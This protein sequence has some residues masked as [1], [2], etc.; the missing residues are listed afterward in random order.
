MPIPKSSKKARQIENLDFFD[1]K[2]DEED[3]A[4]FDH[5]DKPDGRAANQDPAV[6]QE[7]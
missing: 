2:L 6:Y 7:F 1:F 3:L 4:V 5:L